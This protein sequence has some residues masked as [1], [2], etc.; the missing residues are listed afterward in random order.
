MTLFKDKKTL[1]GFDRRVIESVLNGLTVREIAYNFKVYTQSASFFMSIS[2]NRTLLYS[3]REFPDKTILKNEYKLNQ[4]YI[5]T[6]IK[7]LIIYTMH[8]I[9]KS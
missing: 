2:S 4:Q 6:F 7:G 9:F 3:A 8:I 1:S 5:M